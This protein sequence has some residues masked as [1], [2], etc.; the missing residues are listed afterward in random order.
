MSQFTPSQKDI[1][2]LLS[3]NKLINMKVTLYDN[4]YVEVESL[5]GKIKGSP[6]Y[7][8][9]SEA[10]IRRTCA[11]TLIVPNKGSIANDFE[12]T[13]NKRMVELWCGI[14]SNEDH[15]YVWYK[16]GRMLLAS[17]ASTLSADTQEVKLNL[18]DLIA[19][20]TEERG[21]QVGTPVKILEGSVVKTVI[22]DIIALY[23]PY[24]RS[25]NVCD[26]DDTIPYDLETDQGVYPI[27]ILRQIM[28]L[29]PYYEM[30][31]DEDGIFT[32]QQ[33]PIE[34]D[35]PIDI[36]K[37]IMD[38]IL[39][40]ES[41]SVDFSQIK[42]TTEIWGAE[43][44]GDYVAMSTIQNEGKYIVTIDDMFAVLESGKTVTVFPDADSIEGQTMQIQNTEEL[45]IM[46]A[47]GDGTVY[48]PIPAGTMKKDTAYVV[49]IFLDKFVLEGETQ[50]RC[51]VQE[52]T[53]EPTTATKQA[54]K[55]ENAC[56]NVR[57][58]VN[59]DNPFAC[60]I[61]NG[62]IRGEIKQVLTDNDFAKIMTTELAYE[63]ASYENWLK[64]RRQDTVDLEMILI[65]WLNVNNKI[66]YTSPMTNEV[67][68]Y[69]VK[70]ISY[71]FSKWTMKVKACRF[72]PYYPWI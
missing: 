16:L 71:D 1:D 52:I 10:D 61:E 8:L 21:S 3:K 41:K 33:I 23:S 12:K 24:K 45:P 36:S 4:N 62:I 69:L 43:L 37:E 31:Y 58:V 18:V 48:T 26:F 9:D 59:P 32:T 22:K 63:R 6:S 56:N 55:D 30:F 42:N 2:L 34:T 72:Y 28:E 54:Y 27:D 68:Q 39:I 44:S 38:Q 60:Y 50:I 64:C 49:R 40:S 11:M 51:I 15:D 57:W 19:S 20:I 35:S 65:P 7:E 29:F 47:S 17:G 53:S 25:D 67:G 5:Q 46:I 13:W 66:Q 70:S 14:Y